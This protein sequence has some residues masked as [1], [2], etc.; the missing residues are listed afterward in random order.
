SYC[1]AMIMLFLRIRIRQFKRNSAV[2]T[3]KIR[4][5]AV[6]FAATLL[7]GPLSAGVALATPINFPGHHGNLAASATF[8]AR[9]S[10][11]VVTLTNTSSSDVLVPT[12]VLT[13]VFFDIDG[14]PTLT[15]TSAVI[16]GNCSVLFAPAGGSGPNVGGEWAYI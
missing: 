9:G 1:D 6:A 7:A 2:I 16:C 8:E 3:K 14:N 10:N 15:R 12:D 11:L 4:A 5:Y 13:A